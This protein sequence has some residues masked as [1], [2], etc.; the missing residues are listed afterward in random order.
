M[1][2]CRLPRIIVLLF[3]LLI[4]N[5]LSLA[6]PLQKTSSTGPW[7]VYD[8]SMGAGMGV[9]YKNITGAYFEVQLSDG[10]DFKRLWRAEYD[11]L[12]RW[13][14][15][16]LDLSEYA[17]KK[18]KIRLITQH[19]DNRICQDFPFW[20]NPRIITGNPLGSET[21]EVMNL[22]MTPIKHMGG[23]LPDGN[24]VPLNEKALYFGTEGTPLVTPGMVNREYSLLVYAGD[25][26]ITIAGK[27][28][29]GIYMGFDMS[30]DYLKYGGDT[31]DN[32]YKGPVPPP[33]FT[34]WEIELPTVENIPVSNNSEY[35]VTKK[36]G[37]NIKPSSEI[38]IL[39]HRE[40]KYAYQSG[41]L[42]QW[43]PQEM[44][45][46]TN[47]GDAEN[48]WAFAGIELMGIEK[49]PLLIKKIG[50]FTSRN[51]NS[52][53]GLIIDYHTELGY[54]KRVFL[55]LGACS[56]ERYDLRPASW[57]LDDAAFSLKQR[58]LF[59][60]QF[61]DL[62]DK[63]SGQ[64]GR[65]DILIKEYAPKEWDGRI[66]FAAGVQDIEKQAGIKTTLVGINIYTPNKPIKLQKD[67]PESFIKMEN[68]QLVCVL[69]PVNGAL[70]GLWDKKSG[71]KLMDECDDMYSFESLTGISKCTEQLDKA[72]KTTK[73]TDGSNMTCTVRCDNL[74]MPGLVVEKQY[75]IDNNGILSKK[76]KFELNE[77]KL[78]KGFFVTWH[79]N[80]TLNLDFVENGKFG[81]GFAAP[82]R[83]AQGKVVDAEDDAPAEQAGLNESPIYSMKDGT[84][85]LGCYRYKVNNRFVLRSNFSSNRLGWNLFVF[86]DYLGPGKS[87]SAQIQWVK[88]AGDFVAFSHHY[89]NLPELNEF[90]AK[91]HRPKW[92]NNLAADAMYA[93]PE[94][95]PFLRTLSPLPVTNTIWFLNGP[96]G[97]W[98]PDHD[99]PN[100]KHPNIFGL[101]DEIRGWSNNVKVSC[102][103]NFL[104]DAGSDIYKNHPEFGVKDREGNLVSSGINSDS[105]RGP[106]FFFQ[107][108]NPE[109]RET[110]VDMHRDKL[111]KWKLDFLYFDGPGWGAEVIDWEYKDVAQNYDWID[112]FQTTYEAIKQQDPNSIIFV[113]GILPFAQVGYI[114]YREQQW[115]QLSSA[116]W[117]SL[118]FSLFQLKLN[119]PFNYTIVPTYGFSDADPGISAYTILYGWC[120][121]F[122][123][124]GRIP[125]MKAALEFRGMKLV[126]DAV[127]PQW[128]K[129]ETDFEAYGFHK[130]EWGIVNL[131]EHAEQPREVEISIDLKR[132]GI[133][134]DKQI[135]TSVFIMNDSSS[136]LVDDP[137]GSGKQT[138]VWKNIQAFEKINLKQEL[139][140][141][142]P[143]T[144]KLPTRPHLVTSLIISNLPIETKYLVSDQTKCK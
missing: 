73:N 83:V 41:L 67:I 88:F 139:T 120:G 108:A 112:Y 10:G 4:I 48:G 24:E 52:F 26:Y 35:I 125:W 111:K 71:K 127:S 142:V 92:L 30:H 110:L 94:S 49:L 77:G 137:Y 66:W 87:V 28:Q 17:G 138:R 56:D 114:E 57:I 69:S 90:W 12:H 143:A 46:E 61:V 39:S 58:L 8:I 18:I 34:E 21:H 70:C 72:I 51:E 123:E 31:G 62:S 42:C 117:R 2:I 63:I 124:Q 134:P 7:F 141:T 95:I 76:V 85:G 102:Y 14:P 133:N 96:W 106:T 54:Q 59:E 64:T 82:R 89:N 33:V 104:F 99:N 9:G 50:Q 130:N 131:M 84:I 119:E 43:R 22:A 68:N 3:F 16:A 91:L 27:A 20:G 37:K 55:G 129:T 25:N 80:T 135:F 81:A 107:M 109:V 101:S 45:L 1:L 140:L 93:T 126:P 23:I 40:D 36:S 115:K 6:K 116:E 97:N 74:V 121:N 79:N 105:T 32:P 103:N 86:S 11:R 128:W 78:A 136:E 15:Y 113:N 47:M 65:L 75:S 29:P 132:L 122:Y 98:G 19:I 38:M 53:A 118:A 44:T 13:Y 100:S 5:S 144:I 60:T